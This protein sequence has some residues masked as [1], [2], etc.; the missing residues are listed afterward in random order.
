[1]V[2]LPI[3]FRTPLTEG[4]VG[5]LGVLERDGIRFEIDSGR[6][7]LIAPRTLWHADACHR[8]ANLRPYAY[9]RQGMR[10]SR[11]TVRC[12]DVMVLFAEPDPDASCHD[13]ADV[14]IV[15]EVVSPDTAV[16]DRVVKPRIYAGAGIPEYWIVDRHPTDPRDA[17]VE[18]FKLG[19]SGAYQRI[20]QAAL[21]ELEK[22]G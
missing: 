11:T 10:I 9:G 21:S 19:V 5:A 7:I 18:H 13:P 20:G 22:T 16:E 17:S 12:P 8:V 2:T 15:V 1:M 3:E 6:L 4:D 14:A